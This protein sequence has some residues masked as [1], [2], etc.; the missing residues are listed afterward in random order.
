MCEGEAARLLQAVEGVLWFPDRGQ[1][2][3][4][5]RR[6]EVRDL[7]GKA[8]DGA[9]HRLTRYEV[10]KVQDL[11]TD[12]REIVTGADVDTADAR[13]DVRRRCSLLHRHAN[14]IHER[15]S[16]APAEFDPHARAHAH[17]LLG[18]NIHFQP[19]IR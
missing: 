6:L 2:H 10:G 16:R 15:L 1:P 19:K 14:R 13:L 9:P 12:R 11:K 7:W 18:L 4:P 3:T 5:A 17:S 8:K